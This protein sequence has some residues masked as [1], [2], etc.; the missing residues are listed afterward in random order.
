MR[1][2]SHDRHGFPLP[3]GHRFPLPKYRL[4]REA[5]E[6]EGIGEVC[7]SDAA[8]WEL[9]ATVHEH[10]YLDR[11]RRGAL[12]RRE[13]RALGLPWSPELVERGRRSTFGTVHA[14][15]DALA[16]G[17]GMNLG[18]GT[19]HAAFAQGRGYC[20]FNDVVVAIAALRAEAGLGRVLVVDCDVHQGDGTAELLAGDPRSFT[21]SLHG[22]ANYPFHRATSDLDVDLRTG[23]GDDAYLEAL[24]DALA[25][26]VPTAHPDLVFFLAGA[27]PWK[28]DRLGRL[29]LTKAGL[30]ARDAL[31]LDSADRAGAPVCVVLA[32]GYAPDVADTV[33]INLATA[34]AVAHR[35]GRTE[36][37]AQATAPR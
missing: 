26:A 35:T 10:D 18:G 3:Q 25:S 31:V 16:R 33:E 8:P 30:R 29:A 7:G 34:R 12:S 21:L 1:F 27:D 9:L 13:E 14:A 2:W 5:V 37:H 17:L 11:V 23:T 36:D 4:L 20:L 19:H 32:G 24:E 22:G 28:G 6:R 15:R